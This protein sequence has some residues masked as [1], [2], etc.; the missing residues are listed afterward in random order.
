MQNI[1]WFY[2]DNE[3]SRNNKVQSW[4]KA[5]IQKNGNNAD[6]E[7]KNAKEIKDFDDFFRVL[8]TPSLFAEKR[9]IFIEN[10]ASEKKY[11]KS[12]LNYFEEICSDNILIFIDK[13]L[14][15]LPKAL[16]ENLKLEE[17]K[18]STNELN[19]LID[20]I[21]NQRNKKIDFNLKN[22]LSENYKENTLL[23]LSEVK[24]LC[25]IDSTQITM[26]DYEKLCQKPQNLQA[27]A[28]VDLYCKN[29]KA[30]LIYTLNKIVQQRQDIYGLWHLIVWQISLLYKIK[31][32]CTE[33]EKP[34]VI[35]KNQ[36]LAN[37][38]DT[39][40]LKRILSNICQIDHK[41]KY[42]LI[43]GENQIK[44]EI[45]RSLYT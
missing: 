11:D 43:S 1:F 30:E 25:N 13:K 23:L 7:V 29:K 40:K 38:I 36:S 15:R 10:Y 39:P 22:F 19:K 42:G 3:L 45:I 28:I 44:H 20:G 37:S 41:I 17:F 5:F 6:I 31:L 27:F 12:H 24:K 14:P 2:G 34:F 9:L 4:K 16:P 21:C 32:N 35:K 26:Q 18:T 33:N 8:K